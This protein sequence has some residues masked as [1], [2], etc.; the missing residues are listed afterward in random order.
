MSKPALRA[1]GAEAGQARQTLWYVLE[2]T[3][4]VL[5]PFMPFITEEIWQK[6]PGTGES[7]MVSRWPWAEESRRDSEAEREMD[8]LMQVVVAAR[9]LR[10]TQNVPASQ[11]VEITIATGSAASRRAIEANRAA[12]LLLARGTSL[13]FA[14]EASGPTGMAELVHCFGESATVSI[15][16]KSSAQELNAQRARLERDLA[17]LR[18]EEAGL[19]QKLANAEF[20]SRAPRQVIE[21]TESRL[22]EVRER[23][24]ALEEQLSAID[25]MLAK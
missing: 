25:V 23:R 20:M 24:A 5:H 2:G 17:R 11:S 9:K 14:A 7:I 22:R 1:G 19:Q 6:L 15:A 10:A 18:S 8:T 4:R 13:S 3:L 16:V 12:I 21:K